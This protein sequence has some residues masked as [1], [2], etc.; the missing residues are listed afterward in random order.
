M[1]SEITAIAQVGFPILS[2]IIFLPVLAAILMRLIRD[3]ATAVMVATLVSLVELALAAYAWIALDHGT[4]AM[5][6]VE[7]AGRF[8][9]IGAS[10]HLS[11]DG[12]SALF[13]AATALLS[14]LAVIYARRS[15]NENLR[16]YI[17]ML[18]L[19]EASLM[20]AFAA[21]DLMLFWLFFA[22]EIVP[23]YLLI[24]RWG[25]GSARREA[26]NGFA[27]FMGLAAAALLIGFVL[28]GLNAG[29]GTSFGVA[30][31]ASVPVPT[32]IQTIIFFALCL[33]FAIKAPLFPLH[34]WLP[35]VLEQGPMIGMSVFLVGIKLGAYG[36]IRFVLPLVPEAVAE[37]YWLMALMGVASMVYGAMI[38]LVQTNLRRLMAFASVSHMGV[39]MLGIF[40]LNIEGLQGGLLQALNL[41]ITGAGLFFIASFLTARLGT[42]DLS[43]MGELHRSAPMMALGFLIIGLAA[44]G[45]P[46]TSG[47]NGEH[48]VMLG[49]FKKDWMMAVAVGIGTVLTAAYFLWYYQRAFLG[50][51]A[52]AATKGVPDLGG[53][54][55]IILGAIIAVVFWIGLFTTP[56]L[57]TMNAPLLA[58][59]E[60]V[61]SVAAPVADL[62][63]RTA[64]QEITLAALAGATP[65][66]LGR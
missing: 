54:E 49:A 34:T 20:G 46:G 2:A 65:R 32:E 52:S 4:A 53:S 6:M 35:K 9:M 47:F 57:T 45:M 11:I 18:L 17:A 41:G 48:L 31:I 10:Y 27:F 30:D 15:V 50:T 66:S 33:G 3:D 28:L 14:L 38:A 1:T 7:N 43:K 5:Q 51:A 36:F 59:A 64:P 60:R 29:E 12:I 8:P 19:C 42:P 22:A 56:F 25:V 58:V 16:G 40:S 44:V 26:A 23:S 61:S 63:A 37:W 24:A 21:A 13:L 62:G 39:V 55:R